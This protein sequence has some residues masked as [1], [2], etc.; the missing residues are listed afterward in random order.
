MGQ[1]YDGLCRR[2]VA[3]CPD[4][5]RIGLLAALV[6]GT[7][8]H[9]LA[10]QPKPYLPVTPRVDVI[11]PIGNR[12][13]PSHRRKHKRPTYLGG[14]MADVI[15]PS[16]QEAM[17]WRRGVALGWYKHS[18][19]TS[20]LTHQRQPPQRY[21]QHFFYPKPWEALKTGP[22][23]SVATETASS[24]MTSSEMELVQPGSVEE[25]F[26]S[27]LEP[28][29]LPAPSD[30]LDFPQDEVLRAPVTVEPF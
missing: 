6:T 29:P 11:G 28:A 8:G 19:I 23:V 3:A 18:G 25:E 7:A 21:E 9:S 2:V 27:I 16:S 4:Q 15:A 13:P 30:Q 5:M 17:A 20:V 12:L 10:G 1:F 14:K 26:P 24:S 22:R